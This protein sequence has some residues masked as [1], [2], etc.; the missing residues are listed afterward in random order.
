MPTYVYKFTDTG[1]TIEVQQAFTDATL[2]EVAHPAGEVLPVKKVFTPVG[3]TFK[4][5]GFYK[6][7]S[8]EKSTKSDSAAS[9]DSGPRTRRPR[10]RRSRIRGPRIRRVPRRPM[11]PPR[12]P[13][14]RRRRLLLVEGHHDAVEFEHQV[15]QLEAGEHLH[16]HEDLMLIPLADQATDLG[17]E[18]GVFGGS[19][20]L[21]VPRRLHRD[22]GGHALRAQPPS[23]VSVGTLAGRAR[24]L[25]RPPRPPHSFAAHRVPYRANVWAMASVGVRSIIAPCSV[26]SLQPDLAPRRHGDR[27]PDR[28]SDEGP[29]RHVPRRRFG[30]TAFPGRMPRAPPDVRR[31]VRRPAALD[32]ARRGPLPRRVHGARRRHH[33]GDQRPPVL[34]PRREPVVPP[35]GLARGEHDGV[36]RSR[37]RRR[38]QASRTPPVAL[39]TDY[40]AGVD[41]HEPVTMDTVFATLRHNV[42]N[43]RELILAALPALP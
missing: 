24:R 8:R 14:P 25:H 4:G 43:V 6:T 18:I 1:E 20:F 26:G 32:P 40:D 38:S 35:D 37:P 34:H 22:R 33:G 15:G 3:V 2:T 29:R 41:G 39:I 13:G 31:A 21:R 19:G 30:P 10:I 36:P 11:A 5:G 42:A 9:K 23:P 7:D 17:A 27:R 12:R 28:R 16:V